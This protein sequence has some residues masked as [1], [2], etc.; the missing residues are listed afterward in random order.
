MG[1]PF[2]LVQ[3]LISLIVLALAV[4]VLTLYPRKNVKVYSGKDDSGLWITKRNISAKKPYIDLANLG[5]D[6]F[7][8]KIDKSA[9]HRMNGTYIEVRKGPATLYSKITYEGKPF[10]MEA[11]FR[12]GTISTVY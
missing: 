1:Q 11:D 12:E 4:A 5:G 8:L 7:Y 9:S 2:P 6:L 10:R 3:T